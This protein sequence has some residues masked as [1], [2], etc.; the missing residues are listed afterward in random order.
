M[1]H[2]HPSRK[3]AIVAAL[4]TALEAIEGNVGELT[5]AAYYLAVRFARREPVA[6]R[7]LNEAHGSL[8]SAAAEFYRLQVGPYEDG[9][10]AR[11]GEAC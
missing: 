10:I 11:N 8:C 2:I 1:P 7:R 4:D 3:P 6:F 5:F 9:A